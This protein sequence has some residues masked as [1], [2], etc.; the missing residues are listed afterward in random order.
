MH[1]EVLRHFLF[2]FWLLAYYRAEKNWRSKKACY[3]QKQDGPIAR[4]GKRHS[5][6][7]KRAYKKEARRNG[8]N[9]LFKQNCLLSQ[10]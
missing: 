2:S 5:G 10:T 1:S 7:E 9:T 6:V 4:S 3:N 8:L